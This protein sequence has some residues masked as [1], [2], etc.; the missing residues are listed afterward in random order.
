VP[1]HQRRF[2][3][4]V[5]DR[6]TRHFEGARNPSLADSLLERRHDL[7]FFVLGHG[8]AVGLGSKGFVAVIATAARRPAAIGTEAFT[9]GA[10]AVG[11]GLSNHDHNLQQQRAKIQCP[12]NKGAE[13]DVQPA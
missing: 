10:L 8:T 5:T 13:P 11:T 6:Q 9:A 3:S 2:F 12:E 4:Q 1:L 7:G